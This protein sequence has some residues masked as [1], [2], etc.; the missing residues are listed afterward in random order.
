VTSDADN[1]AGT[2]R[3]KIADA[4][5]TII[6]FDPSIHLI[7]STSGPFNI[8]HDLAIEGPGAA[9]LSISGG[10]VPTVVIQLGGGDGSIP[11]K[12]SIDGVTI[13]DGNGGD[14]GGIIAYGSDLTITNSVV[15]DNTGEAYAGGIM[16]DGTLTMDRTTVAGNTGISNGA[17]G[18]YA[19]TVAITNST[20]S[21]N[22]GGLGIGG[23]RIALGGTITNTTVSGNSGHF[24][25]G[26]KDGG[27]G[28][29]IGGTTRLVNVTVTGNSG[30]TAGGV[31]GAVDLRLSGS[32]I[33]G[34]TGSGTGGSDCYTAGGMTSEGHNLFGDATGCASVPT[35][36]DLVGIAPKLGD[37]ADNG[38]P[39][40]T[41]LPQPDSPL[42][43]ALPAA[44]CTV[45]ADQRGQLRPQNG[46][47]D[48]GA[49]EVAHSLVPVTMQLASNPA[50][51]A[52]PSTNVTFTATVSDPTAN[53]L[54]QAMLSVG[55]TVS[56]FDGGSCQTPGS[57]LGSATVQTGSAFVTASL[58]TVGHHAVVACFSGNARYAAGEATVAL[59]ILDG[60]PPVIT[61]SGPTSYTVDQTV[62]ITCN[63]ADPESGIASQCAGE[64]G[65]A[66]N[67][68]IG[69]NMFT[70][71]ATNGAGLSASATEH[72]TVTLTT[73]GMLALI[74]R[75]V[76]GK[77]LETLTDRM[78]N[79]ADK[80][81]K[82]NPA[83]EAQVK[84]F[85]KELDSAQSSGDISAANA[86]V[87]ARLVQLFH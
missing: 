33:A 60:T 1:G 61:F 69:D 86:A 6:Q 29:G 64:S 85:L 76:S 17:G 37:L 71:S 43:D 41:Q 65:P 42:I 47:C 68:S 80:V 9:N 35:E 44:D 56:F 39:T 48:I 46:A 51:S 50:G 53:N 28:A 77:S 25:G 84:N 24:I 57:P 23:L 14:A 10:E 19:G 2:F 21:G 5:C 38:G 30:S 27:G 74:T 58:S 54:Q 49:V 3:E 66:Y 8:L 87:L 22:N 75:F 13:R 40:L 81:A 78:A 55:T 63:A 79:I 7:T 34:N 67:F 83:V 70:T 26:I 12:A 36:T 32:V 72:F 16:V 18:V 15:R 62:A 4:S 59:E 31:V 82:H 45:H 20:I 52:A 73:N 11:V